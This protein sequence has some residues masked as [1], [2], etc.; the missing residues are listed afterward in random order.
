MK[1]YGFENLFVASLLSTGI[2]SSIPA[3]AQES[4]SLVVIGERAE[5]QSQ[6]LDEK[7][8]L[9]ISKPAGYETGEDRYPVLYLL[10]GNRHFHH[11]TGTTKFLASRDRMPE[12]LVVAI[13]NTNRNRDL[14]PPYQSKEDSK[15]FPNQGGADNFLRFI[16]DELM[17]WVER[18]YR[19]RPYRI[20]VGHSYGG[21]FAIHTLIT[22]PGVFNA[23]IA[24]SPSLQWDNQ[25]LVPKAEA[26]FEATPELD[27]DF[28]MT[29]GNESGALLDG[30]RKLSGVLDES[31]PNGFRWNFNRMV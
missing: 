3:V 10:D 14:T 31:A 30:V 8:V 21:L 18:N 27:A 2:L 6:I 19:T 26:F 7:R 16:S 5:L 29:A 13:P 23:Y 28:F 20:L 11:T 17:P 4:P 12:V 9:I 15:R 22:R 1:K 24:I 25:G